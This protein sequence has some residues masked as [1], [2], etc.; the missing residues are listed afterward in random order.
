M[1]NNNLYFLEGGGEMGELTR[2]KDWAI[3][4]MGPPNVWPQSLRI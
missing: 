2:E 4:S 3:T 1:E